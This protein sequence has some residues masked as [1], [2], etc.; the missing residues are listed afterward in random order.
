MG[1]VKYM[2]KLNIYLLSILLFSSSLFIS[3][4]LVSATSSQIQSFRA[5]A[6]AVEKETAFDFF[7]TS[8]PY[9]TVEKETHLIRKD[10]DTFTQKI[11]SFYNQ[12]GDLVEQ[13]I[14][15]NEEYV[16]FFDHGVETTTIQT[17]Y[18]DN[19]KVSFEQK[20]VR[21]IEYSREGKDY[22]LLEK[23]YF[24]IWE[25]PLK[26]IS[27][28][29]IN[30]GDKIHVVENIYVRDILQELTYTRQYPLEKGEK[31]TQNQVFFNENGSI[32]LRRTR[33]IERKPLDEITW[34]TTEKI[35][36]YDQGHELIRREYLTEKTISENTCF[37]RT[38]RKEVWDKETNEE[39]I[40]E[41]VEKN[42]R[43]R[44]DGKLHII[45]SRE[46]W[47]SR[48]EKTDV[49][50][51]EYTITEIH[52]KDRFL[53]KMVMKNFEND[54]LVE[55]TEKNTYRYVDF[56]IDKIIEYSYFDDEGRYHGGE[57]ILYYPDKVVNLLFDP[58]HSIVERTIT[59]T[60]FPQ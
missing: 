16:F 44:E 56:Q 21:D 52:G 40:Y 23:E 5:E 11:I 38:I 47:D 58:E 6:P 30:T 27:K 35:Y 48:L 17:E 33:D 12:K 19:R 50:R 45:Q 26:K 24:D 51:D 41:I 37:I 28:K 3:A 2:F 55:Y 43:F 49:F 31:K 22:Q 39:Y 15:D 18:Q 60:Y 10:D 57:R 32:R 8:G 13:H 42:E 25:R 29:T 34:T 14:I 46:K 20:H 4:S 1:K 9:Y 53:E 36:T 7:D 54:V 59:Y